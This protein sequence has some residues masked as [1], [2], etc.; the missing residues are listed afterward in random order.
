MATIGEVIRRLREQANLTQADLADAMGRTPQWV[1]ALENGKIGAKQ[2]ILVKIA[3][4]MGVL[5]EKI[6]RMAGDSL[7]P[8]RAAENAGIPV[9]NKAL[10]GIAWDYEAHGVSSLDGHSYME[11]LAGEESD[12]LIAVEVVGD[13]MLP[14]LREQDLLVLWWVPQG[15]P[16]RTIDGRIVLA[17]FAEECGGR[18]S[19]A[20]LK[21]TGEEDEHRGLR[22]RLVKLNP[23]HKSRDIWLT[24]LH[25]LAVAKRIQRVL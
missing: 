13:S 6:E 20:Q 24:D 17:S 25:R 18:V 23:A 9:V 11:R 12:D 1:S 19:L 14:E 4:A 21:F 3:A 15:V 16:P 5:P 7:L 10:A 2:P 22:A 8:L